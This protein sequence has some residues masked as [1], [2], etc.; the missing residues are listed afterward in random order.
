MYP[1]EQSYIP[2]DSVNIE[3]HINTF[4]YI[5]IYTQLFGWGYFAKLAVSYAA[6]L[7]ASQERLSSRKLVS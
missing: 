5:Y 6:Q 7:A 4:I 1:N 2:N 3:K